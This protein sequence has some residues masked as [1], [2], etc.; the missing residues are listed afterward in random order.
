MA[1]ITLAETNPAQSYFARTITQHKYAH[2]KQG[3]NKES[4]EEIASRVAHSVMD[5]YTHSRNTNHVES[6]IKDRK[7]M[8]GGRYLYASGRK[9]HQINNCLGGEEKIITI[10][11]VRTL[12]ELAEDGK[13]FMVLN[14]FGVWN[15]ATAGCFGKQKLWRIKLSNGDVIR[16]TAAHRWWQADGTRVTTEEVKKIPLCEMT[17][18][19]VYLDEEGIKHGICYGD[20]TTQRHT[21]TDRLVLAQHKEELSSYFDESRQLKQ[22]LTISKLPKKYKSL[23][24]DRVCSVEYARGFIAGLIATDGSTKT[25]MITISLSG[26]KE[27]AEQVRRLAVL[28]GCVVNGIWKDKSEETNYGKRST[29]LYIISIKPFSAP[30]I[31]SDQIQDVHSK[32]LRKTKMYLT[33]ENITEEETEEDVYCCVVPGSESFTLA[34]GLITSNCFLFRADDSREG[35]AKIMHDTTNAL[36]TGGGVGVVY[37][38][39][40]GSET[41]VEGMGGTC[42][43]PLALMRMVNEAGREIMQGGSRRAAIWAGLRWD[44]PDIKNFVYMKDWPLDLQ[45]MR[46]KNFNFPCPMDGTNISVILDTQFFKAYRDKSHEKHK[47]AQKV[48]WS[49]VRQMLKTGEP[50][51]SVD[52]GE[53]EGE[54]NRN[55]PVHGDTRVLTIQGYRRAYEL[56]EGSHTVWTGNQWAHNITFKRTAENTKTVRVKMTGGREIVCDPSHPFIVQRFSGKGSHRKLDSEE[57]IPAGQLEEG[58]TIRVSL[59]VSSGSQQIQSDQAYTM[60]F[61]WGDGSLVGKSRAEVAICHESKKPCAERFAGISSKT[62]DSRG[63]D[64]YYFNQNPLYFNQSKERIPDVLKTNRY[65][66]VAEFL[67]GLFDADGNV[68]QA[69]HRIR[70]SS[71]KLL[72]L[73]ECQRLLE[74]LGVLSSIN[75]GSASGYTG[76]PTWMLVVSASYVK[77]FLNVVPTVRLKMKTDDWEPYREST[78]KVISVTPD[79]DADVYC[80]D[81]KVDEHTFCAEGVIISNCCEVTSRF[82]GDMCNLSSLNLARYATIEEFSEAVRMG[83]LLLLCGTMYSKLP[84]EYMYGVREKTRRL[85][86]GLMGVHEW[87]LRRGYKYEAGNEELALW[88]DEYKKSTQ[89]AIDWADSMGI[90]RPVATRSIAP[91]GTISIVAETTSGIEPIFAVAYKRR[92]LKKNDWYYQHVIDAT[93]QRLIQSGVNPD[94]IEDSYTLSEDVERRIKFQR[95]MQERVDHGISSTINLP[96]WGSTL[97]SEHTVKS[98]GEKLLQDLPGLRGMTTYPDGARPGQPIVPMRYTEA[99]KHISRGEVE[100]KETGDESCK[101]GFCNS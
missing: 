22:G 81:V 85:G 92:Y 26:E 9:Y 78:I 76:N 50:G 20:G 77:Q 48:Y 21:K 93:A 15:H 83:T 29:P 6:L 75:K 82:N 54:N 67:A 65:E 60:G 95:W 3:G 57:R 4:W 51:F 18:P 86:L 69:Q 34:N 63:Y 37:S 24:D 62:V 10:R 45:E 19:G 2:T 1:A 56:T 87:L 39:I 43:G 46:T 55:A 91:T 59:P 44:H 61:I 98:F 32:E 7:L 17:V 41:L 96:K 88:M 101:G 13:R 100:V 94:L 12:K 79:Q 99:V 31:R 40:R 71:S 33:V 74:T 14:R 52:I 80:C 11:G 28:G 70:L 90:S 53:N 84:I 42:S 73:Q 30:L 89:H 36:M 27:E 66:W 16:A 64:R 49:T 97:N 58:D 72:F 8:P 38:D 5:H 47:L 68:D 25:S 35:W 23:P